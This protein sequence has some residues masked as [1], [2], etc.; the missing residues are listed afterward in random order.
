MMP[1]QKITSAI[2]KMKIAEIDCTQYAKLINQLYKPIIENKDISQRMLDEIISIER[3][4]IRLNGN[5]TMCY[6][7]L[8]IAYELTNISYIMSVISY[9]RKKEFIIAD[10]LLDYFNSLIS[11]IKN[12]KKTK[13]LVGTYS[14]LFSEA[15]TELNFSARKN[16]LLSSRLKNNIATTKINK[17]EETL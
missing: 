12:N 15:I 3:Q 9:F 14:H 10:L 7:Y 17:K 6:E 5:K 2:D 13:Y 8:A 11:E 1:V 16:I 4:R